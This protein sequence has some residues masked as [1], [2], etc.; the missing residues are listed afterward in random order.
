M[1]SSVGRI[2]SPK[3]MGSIPVGGT[4]PPTETMSAR[5][6]AAYRQSIFVMSPTGP[7]PRSF[8]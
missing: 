5:C 4:I 1:L 6:L 2:V 8:S 7:S 3:G